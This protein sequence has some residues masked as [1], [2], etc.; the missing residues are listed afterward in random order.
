MMAERRLRF[1]L[2]FR[3]DPTVKPICIPFCLIKHGFF[4]G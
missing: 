4:T 2:R 1:D 3:K